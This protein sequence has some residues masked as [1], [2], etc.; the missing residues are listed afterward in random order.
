MPRPCRRGC[1][2][3]K[4]L[5]SRCITK[6]W[7]AAHAGSRRRTCIV[8][9]VAAFELGGS[10]CLFVPQCDRLGAQARCKSGAAIADRLPAIGS[11][12]G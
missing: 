11:V 2:A 3:E 10:G 8:L 4:P 6:A 5:A 1:L 12:S 7:G 9:F